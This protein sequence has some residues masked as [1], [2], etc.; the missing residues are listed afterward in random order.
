[1]SIDADLYD[2]KYFIQRD[3]GL[4]AK[5][6]IMYRQ[7]VARVWAHTKAA[8][9]VLDVGC[10]IG[11]F[12]TQFDDRWARYGYDPSEFAAS[13][14]AA[15]GVIMFRNL[16]SIDAES[17]DV[18]IFRGTLQHI[19]TPIEDLVQATRILRKGGWLVIL[20]TPDADSLVYKIWGNLPALDAPRNWIVFGT[21]VLK[22]IV[23]RLSYTDIEI[24]RPYLGSPYADPIRDF[25]KFTISLFLGWRK[26]AFW[27]NMFELYCRKV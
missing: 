7:E 20:A 6:Q 17:M 26:F 13:K 16:N 24:I 18:V 19:D 9:S 1:M 12:I 2:A 22:N 25:A 14:A 3:Y 21:R 5:R 15:K 23:Q 10:G 4:D 8:G 11:E 27:G